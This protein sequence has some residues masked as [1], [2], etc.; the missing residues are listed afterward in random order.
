MKVWASKPVNKEVSCY[1]TTW[2]HLNLRRFIVLCEQQSSILSYFTR[3]CIFS[4]FPPNSLLSYQ[5]EKQCKKNQQ[6]QVTEQ[7]TEQNQAYVGMDPTKLEANHTTAFSHHPNILCNFPNYT[8]H[9]TFYMHLAWCT[10]TKWMQYSALLTPQPSALKT[11]HICH[12]QQWS[13]TT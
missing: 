12:V 5:P 2:K 11:I 6:E 13:F 9:K 7:F 10:L 4:A 3:P 1:N 8:H